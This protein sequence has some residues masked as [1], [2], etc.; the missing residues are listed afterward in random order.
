MHRLRRPGFV[1]SLAVLVIIGLT[2]YV[3]ADERSALAGLWGEKKQEEAA[4]KVG[5]TTQEYYAKLRDQNIDV[6]DSGII[7]AG[8]GLTATYTGPEKLFPAYGKYGSLFSFLPLIR[9]YDPDH[10]YNSAEFHPESPVQGTFKSDE[11]VICHTVQTP[12]I[13]AQWRRSEHAAPSSGKPAVGC[14]GCHGSDHQKLTMPSY[15]TCGE[16]HKEQ[17]ER[18]RTGGPGSHAKAYDVSVLEASWQIEKPAEEVSPCATC[19]AIIQNRCDGCH[20]RHD[21]SLAEARKP[22][23]CGVCHTGLDHYEY[24]MYAQSYH[25]MIYEAQGAEW[26]W[27]RPLKPENYKTPTCAYCHMQDGDHNPMEPSTVHSNMGTALVDRGAPKYKKKREGWVK[28]CQDCHSPRFARDQLEA[29]DEA[30]KLSFTKYREAMGIIGELYGEG[31]LDPMPTDL[32]PDWTGHFTFSLFPGGEGRMH[33]TSDIERLS[34]EM[35]VYITNSV[36]KAMS[37]FA[38]YNATYGLGAF[39]QDR[40]L[41]QIKAEASRLKRF[42]ALEKEVGITHKADKFWKHGEYIDL[43]LGWKIKEGK[44]KWPVEGSSQ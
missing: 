27:N 36:Y 15:N 24:E 7:F 9:W 39:K 26:N 4:E 43:L 22:N 42:A 40:W 3:P 10:Y 37:H 23:N 38:W 16:C 34:F 8:G 44:L 2:L 28:I 41:T 32:A 35:L 6:D 20:T 13:V 21:F 14:D 31:V 30:V 25:G 5:L 1:L 29:M 12:G 11:C 17:M 33:N 18:H 19:H